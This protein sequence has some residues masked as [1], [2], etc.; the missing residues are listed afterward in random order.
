M[1]TMNNFMPQ[2]EA[3]DK[4]DRLLETQNLPGLNHPNR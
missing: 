2:M 4:T 3:L 1:S